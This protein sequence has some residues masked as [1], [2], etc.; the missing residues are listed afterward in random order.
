MKG[1]R[2]IGF[3]LTTLFLFLSLEVSANDIIAAPFTRLLGL[4]DAYGARKFV[5]REVVL[6]V[7]GSYNGQLERSAATVATDQQD[8]EAT[9]AQYPAARA[10]V[11]GVADERRITRYERARQ[12]SDSMMMR[13][14]APVNRRAQADHF[15][16]SPL[17]LPAAAT[18]VPAFTVSAR[19][20]RME[21][22]ADSTLAMEQG[23]DTAMQSDSSS[24]PAQTVFLR[25]SRLS[26]WQAGI[27]QEEEDTENRRSYLSSDDDE[28]VLLLPLLLGW[29]FDAFR[30]GG[31]SS[32]PLAPIPEPASVASLLVGVGL[33]AAVRNRGARQKGRLHGGRRHL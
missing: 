31:I 27:L 16:R 33:L 4:G 3:V 13:T 30:S 7:S 29:G 18:P 19:A 15:N 12:D 1:Y 25:P 32:T 17:L 8:E 20:A 5:P 9:D 28:I 23:L 6:T 14:S 10:S 21:P 22:S 26:F 2:R 24:K 11:E